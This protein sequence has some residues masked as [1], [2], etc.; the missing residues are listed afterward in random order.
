M[1]GNNFPDAT[2][3]QVTVKIF[4]TIFENIEKIEI[5]ALGGRKIILSLGACIYDGTGDISYDTLYS[6]ADAA[7]YRS[8][9][10]QGFCATVHGAADEVFIP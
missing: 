10:Q 7:M 6:K 8:K 3:R 5:K 1:Y 2:E 4:K 9:K